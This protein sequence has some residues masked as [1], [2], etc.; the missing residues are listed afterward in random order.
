MTQ[1]AVSK[2]LLAL[3]ALA[4]VPLFVRTPY[5]LSTTEA[6]RIYV[7][8]ARIAL[9]AMENAALRVAA[10]GSSPNAIKLHILPIMG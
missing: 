5:G 6:G 8:E 7:V 1:S 3:E 9:G 4:G 2:Q 10:L